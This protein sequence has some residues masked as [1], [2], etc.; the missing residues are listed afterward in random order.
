MEYIFQNDIVTDICQKKLKIDF[1]KQKN[2]N[3]FIA[4]VISS[5]TSPLRF[6]ENCPMLQYFNWLIPN[7]KLHF[8]LSS[9]SP[10]YHPDIIT[11]ESIT[12]RSITNETFYPNSMLANC[13]PNYSELISSLL[14]YRGLVSPVE[15]EKAINYV[16]D[17][18]K[19]IFN[20]DKKFGFR[21]I[22]KKPEWI[23]GGDF[24]LLQISVSRI[25]NSS[26]LKKFS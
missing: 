15:V 21:I 24:P 16:S 20:S 10:I 11:F 18:Y 1:P 19:I 2:I 14:I 26:L 25:T 22:G 4:Q 9:Y 6:E 23:M 8:L 5:I 17:K 3:R 13:P 12:V 7:P